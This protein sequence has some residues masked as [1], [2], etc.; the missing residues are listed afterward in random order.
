MSA[1]TWERRVLNQGDPPP[2]VVETPARIGT[3]TATVIEAW[4]RSFQVRAASVF[5]GRP[6]RRGLR[7][8]LRHFWSR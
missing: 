5:S 2:I 4:P 3:G 1:T 8:A 7:R 6:P